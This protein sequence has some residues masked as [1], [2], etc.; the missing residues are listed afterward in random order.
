M[1]VSNWDKNFITEYEILKSDVICG[2]M[3][4]RYI[5]SDFL[6]V[7]KMFRKGK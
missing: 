3:T 6:F 5:A 2:I 4:I 7:R 1:Q